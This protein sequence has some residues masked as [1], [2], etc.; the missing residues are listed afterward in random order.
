MQSTSLAVPGAAPNWHFFF[1]GPEGTI[2]YYFN[3]FN[4]NT[5]INNS[6]ISFN[7]H[8]TVND[9]KTVNNRE[10]NESM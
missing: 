2:I 7:D 8:E 5:F 3:K 4:V 10:F 9:H 6:V 1:N